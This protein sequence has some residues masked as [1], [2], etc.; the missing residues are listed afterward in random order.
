MTGVMEFG[1]YK[2]Y[3][4]RE[5]PDNYLEWLIE[6]YERN[7]RLW[8]SELDRRASEAEANQTWLQRLISAGY[9]ALAVKHHPD[10]GGLE[11]DMKAINAA[12]ERLKAMV[13]AAEAD[14]TRRGG[15]AA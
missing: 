11:E 14:K 2:G 1:K 8:R 10:H 4:L 5:V 12:N 3:P 9:K 7:V 15:K 6:S 13:A